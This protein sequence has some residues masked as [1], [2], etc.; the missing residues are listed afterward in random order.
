MLVLVV[1]VTS[2]F[3]HYQEGKSEDVMAALRAMA[4]VSSYCYRDNQL[5]QVPTEQLVIGDVVKVVGGERVPADLR[6][7]ASAELKVNNA[8]LT[9]ENL[10]IRLKTEAGHKDLFEARNIARSGCNFTSGSGECVIFSTGDDTFFGQIAS[11]TLNIDRPTSLLT[12]E[13]RRLIRIMAG[14]AITLGVIFFAL[15][16]YKKY[17]MIEAIVF[18]IGIVVANVP[19]GLL[20]QVTVALTLT[21]QRM[22]KLGMLVTNLEVIETL[23]ATSVICSDKTGTLTCNR[24]TVSHVVYNKTIT[25]TPLTPSLTADKFDEYD[26]RDSSFKALQRAATLCSD[27]VFIEGTDVDVMTRATKGDASETALLRFF[28]PIRSIAEFRATCPRKA[29][30]PFDSSLKWM[31]SVNVLPASDSDTNESHAFVTIKGAPER[32]FALC[33]T[34]LH[35]SGVVPF[36]QAQQDEFVLLNETLARRGERVLAFAQLA[37]PISSFP[38][39]SFAFVAE[40]PSECNFPLSGLTLLGLVS[41]VD[42]PRQG[43]KEAIADC[44][45]A[46]VRVVMITGDHPI[47]AHAIAKS[48]DII[49]GPVASEVA[50]GTPCDAIVVHGQDMLEFG[51]ADWDRVLQHSEVVFARTMPKQKQD[52]VRELRNKKHI[53]TMT[54]DGVNDAPALKAAHVGIAM[55]SGTAVAKEASQIILLNDE[56]SSVVAGVREGRLI[57]VNLKKCISYVLSSNVPEIVPFLL[58]IALR[59]PLAIET[60][61]IL[62]IDLG[63]D[64][65]P[66]V[67]LAFEEPEDAIMLVPPRSRDSHLVDLK[68][69]LN[70]YFTIGIFETL[71]GMFAFYAVF[72]RHGFSA[73][74]LFGA[75]EDYSVHYDKLP[76]KR[77]RFFEKMCHKNRTYLQTGGNCENEFFDFRVDVLGEAQ[78]VYLLTIVWGQLANILVRK[79]DVSSIFTWKRLMGN[80]VM[81][82]SI[83]SEIVLIVIIC[84]VPQV[85]DGLDLRVPDVVG[86]FIG[87]WVV[88]LVILWEEVRKLIVRRLWKL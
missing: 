63:T 80:T 19:E 51:Q 78:A 42:P 25:K 31:A 77:Q 85:A 35:D 65:A 64:L 67:S 7:L 55:G 68:L 74:S 11:A 9:G 20:P 41:L 69:M 54:G 50:P 28:E 29:A 32:V 24:M 62:L 88:V 53:V 66:T 6:V 61:V 45:R 3:Q 39:D 46:G 57:F 15:A 48:L 37:L 70:S 12:Q 40:D 71:A 75:G 76:E 86:S 13:I 21:A 2:V 84:F 33:S 18:M 87:S 16:L 4:S 34:V 1:V 5:V 8:P 22:L 23:G 26:P 60:I 83:V 47:T 72:V 36:D 10:D 38:P 73:G 44:H 79:T 49:T 56:F 59:I 58:F 14:F 81:L 27:A 43:V 30:I 82:Q 17:T 52:I